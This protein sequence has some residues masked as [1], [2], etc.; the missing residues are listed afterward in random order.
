MVRVRVGLQ[1]MNASLYNFPKLD[2]GQRV[3]MCVY[4]CMFV[5]VCPA[6]YLIAF[7]EGDLI[8]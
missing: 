1:E 8:L 6:E 5:C 4:L 2:Q 3:C 7:D